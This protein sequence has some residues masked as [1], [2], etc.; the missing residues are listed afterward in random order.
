MKRQKVI[1]LIVVALCLAFAVIISLYHKSDR[2]G[3]WSLIWAFS[4]DGLMLIMSLYIGYLTVGVTRMLFGL[5][6]PVYFATKLLYHFS[7]FAGVYVISPDAWQYVWS[8]LL[9]SILLSGI[10]YCLIYISHERN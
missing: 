2:E 5:I 9:I 8:I 6:L 1:E 7:C 4:E 3:S 10:I